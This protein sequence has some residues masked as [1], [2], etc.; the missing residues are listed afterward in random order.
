MKKS[1]PQLV[2]LMICFC[3]SPYTYGQKKKTTKIDSFY[4]EAPNSQNQFFKVNTWVSGD[5]LRFPN[6]NNYTNSLFNSEKTDFSLTR[7]IRLKDHSGEK[8]IPIEIRDTTSEFLLSIN[9]ALQSGFLT[10]EIYDPTGAKR[11]NFSVKG[12]SSKSSSWSE[13]VGSVINKRFMS[14]IKGTW[15]LKFIAEKVT[16]DILINTNIK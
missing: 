4:Y 9:C 8:T 3:I 11:G 1:F 10:V 5:S 13:D 12:D 6:N 7:T 16:A 2:I 14:P 15:S